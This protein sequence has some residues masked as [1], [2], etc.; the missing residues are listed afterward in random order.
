MA[1]RERFGVARV[2][3]EVIPLL[4]ASEDLD[5]VVFATREGLE[6]LGPVDAEVVAVGGVPKSVWEQ[7][8]LPWHARR[9]GAEIIYSHSECAPAW[10]P[11]VLLHVPEDP[12]ARWE[13]GRATTAKERLRR[14]YQR[15]VTPR[16][17]RR[18]PLLVTSC[19]SI[20][21]ALRARFGPGL[22]KIVVVPLGVDTKAFYPDEGP[23]AEGSVFHLGSPSP[24]DQTDLVV[25]A[26]R[27]AVSMVPDLPDL[28]VA[29]ELGELGASIHAMAKGSGISSRVHLQGRVSDE[30]LRRCYAH[31]ALC[32]QPARYEGF[33]LQPLEALACGAPL[34]VIEEPAVHE[35]VGEAAVVVAEQSDA[36]LAKAMVELWSGGARRGRLRK[37]GPL[38]AAMFP[39][40]LTAS[41]L[42]DLLLAPASPAP[43]AEVL[44][45]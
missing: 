21:S 42:R 15:L 37:A 14:R 13:T 39:W 6:L 2:L 24:R 34:I 36:A 30:E 11:P 28:V 20:A 33:G 38:R 44:A 23:P 41:R 17:V 9:A 3:R 29:G 16:S 1:I 19:Q 12:Y 32:V 40:Q 5:C 45:D 43:K 35:V 22:P 7:T 4:A 27:E 18:A 25:R 10:G 8:G 31:A 26:Y